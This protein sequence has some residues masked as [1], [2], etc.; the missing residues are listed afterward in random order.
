MKNLSDFKKALTLGS[1]WETIYHQGTFTGRDEN[2]KP[3]YEAKSAGVRPVSIVQS[4]S[5]AF[6][7]LRGDG[8]TQDSWLQ[9]PKAKDCKFPNEDTIEVYEG[10]TL[11]LT[12]KRTV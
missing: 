9:W 7:T 6:K 12:Y 1:N 10:G 5:V 3:I 8:A 2:G 4:N 11:I